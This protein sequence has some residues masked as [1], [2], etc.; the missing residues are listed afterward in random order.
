[1]AAAGATA[2]ALIPPCELLVVIVCYHAA[3]L[4]IDCL[5]TLAPEVAARP[6]VRVAICEN[7]SGPACEAR[8]RE[9]I[10]REGW[11][12][13]VSLTAI[14]PNRGFAG[15]NDMILRAALAGSAP[16][17]LY[18][19]LN[20]D[21]LVRPGALAELLEAAARHPEAGVIGPRLE[22]PD[23]EPQRSCFRDAGPLDELIS[24]AASGPVS[25]LF[26]RDS[27]AQPV[28]DQPCE[29][30]NV[31]FAAAVI[32]REVFERIGLLDEDYYLYFDDVDFCW[33]ARQAGWKVL[34]WPAA[35]VVHLIGRS[36]PMETLRAARKRRPGY[37]YE[38]RARYFAKRGG[39][40]YLWLANLMWWGGRVISRS[41]EVLLRSPRSACE[42]EWLDIWTHGW[43][44]FQ[45][46]RSRQS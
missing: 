7:G 37:F 34:Y 46:P 35:R 42:R 45:P 21:T 44:P 41:R 18:L 27:V 28:R 4:T 14:T 6:G 38:S 29:A 5:R 33:R 39:R 2:P 31:S 11:Q 20:S 32:R 12:E 8:L 1:M 24:A 15:G 10:E 17:P 3:E 22:W 16:P 13:W 23:G 30:Q 9:A 26:G 43:D 40:R 25:R 36:N 19:L